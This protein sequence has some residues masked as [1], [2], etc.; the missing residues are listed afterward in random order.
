MPQQWIVKRPQASAPPPPLPSES[1]PHATLGTPILTTSYATD[2]NNQLLI[3][4]TIPVSFPGGSGDVTRLITHLLAPDTSVDT[5][6]GLVG[7]PGTGGTVPGEEVPGLIIGDATQASKIVP[8]DSPA[9]VIDTQW[10]PERPFIHF[11]QPSPV[12]PEF[13]KAIVVS[14][15]KLTE[16]RLADSPSKRFLAEPKKPDVS[17]RE[18]APLALNFHLIDPDTGAVT[19]QPYYTLTD[20]GIWKWGFSCVWENDVKDPRYPVLGGYDLEIV[21]PDLKVELHASKSANDLRHDSPLWDIGAPGEFTVRAV[22]WSSRPGTPRNSVIPDLT[23]HV[24]FSVSTPLGPPGEQYTSVVSGQRLVSQDYG[25]AG[26]GSRVQNLVLDWDEPPD[27][28]SFSGV[29][30]TMQRPGKPKATITGLITDDTITYPLADFPTAPEEVTFAFLSVDVSGNV[31]PYQPGVTPELTVT[32]NPPPLGSTGQEYAGLI[33]GQRLVDPYYGKAGSGQKVLNLPLQWNEPADTSYF[34]ALITLQRPGRAEETITGTVTDDRFSY[35]MPDFPVAPEAVTFR[36]YS[37]DGAG[38]VNTF[39]SGTTPELTVT[40]NPPPATLPRVQTGSFTASVVYGKDE[41]GGNTYG[42]EGAW[43][44]PDKAIYPEYQ[45]VKVFW[46]KT[47]TL[48]DRRDLTGIVT[49]QKFKTAMWPLAA[50]SGIWLY[51]ISVDVN[52]VEAPFHA[53]DTPHVGPLFVTEQGGTISNDALPD[54]DVANFADGIEPIKF[55]TQPVASDGTLSIA[56]GETTTV[57]NTTDD[58]LYRWQDAIGKYKQIGGGPDIS[59]NEIQSHHLISDAV[60]AG[61]VAA[62]AIKTRELAGNEILVGPSMAGLGNPADRPPIL[63]VNNATGSMVGLFGTY[64]G[65]EGIYALNLRVGPSFAFPILEATASGLFLKA[66]S[67]DPNKAFSFRMTGPLGG[68]VLMDTTTYDASYA[69]LGVLC[70]DPGDVNKA[71]QTWHVSRGIVLQSWDGSFTR[72]LLAAVRHP[73]WDAGEVILYNRNDSYI[74]PNASRTRVYL[75]ALDPDNPSVAKGVVRADV[76]QTTSPLL[77]DSDE[78][79]RML[80]FVRHTG[81]TGTVTVA[82]ADGGSL[83]LHFRGGILVGGLP[84]D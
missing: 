28:P 49:E 32:L 27:D 12:A 67:N 73:S 70:S 68:Y 20:A 11:V 84:S 5:Q 30:L 74:A 13:W 15:S 69:S 18:Y 53:E 75:S 45:G 62:G 58:R 55:V 64:A 44:N 9:I 56:K 29:I 14:A 39:Q 19:D 76:Y 66:Q 51:A 33:T 81:R 72:K 16:N 71:I 8:I 80:G 43:V 40:L 23:P 54:L 17:G 10:D 82:L 2:Q 6:E 25:K 77:E 3:D 61:K 1:L 37:V 48:S 21:Y 50:D 36:F 60:T 52:G 38:N 59:A 42:Y 63:K 26:D 35:V 46:T 31:N 41:F 79:S 78:E 22:S 7:G 24:T 83:I 47:R 4:V 65:W 34:G 57:F